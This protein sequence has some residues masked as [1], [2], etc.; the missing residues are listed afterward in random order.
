MDANNLLWVLGHKIRPLDTDE[1]YGMVGHRL[2][3]GGI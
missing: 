2:A 3:A 1:S